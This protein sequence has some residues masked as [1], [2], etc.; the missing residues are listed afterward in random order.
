M[1]ASS[2]E[3]VKALR[4]SLKEVESLRRR[5]HALTTAAF[6]PIAIVGMACRYPGDV[7]S[8][9]E[10]WQL[11][12]SGG[13]AVSGFPEDRGWDVAGL[14][15]PDPDAVGK[16]Y[17]RSGGFLSGAA[18]FDP[19]FFGISPREATA[20]HPQQRVL[21]EV[22]WE[23]LE[24]AGVDPTAV[25]GSRTGVFAG[26][27]HQ[28]YA[29]RLHKTPDDL[30]GYLMTGSL[31]SVVS[32]RVAYTLGLE[33]PA[34]TV[35]TACSSSLVAL[36]LAGQSLRAGECSMALV[37][38]VTVMTTP[39]GFVEFSRQRGLSPDGRCK[40]FAASA[41][42]TGWG[43]GVGVLVLERLSDARRNNHRVLAVLRGSAIN[44]DGSSSGFSAPNGPAQERAITQALAD[45]RLGPH[46]V[47]AVEAHGTGTRLGDPIE[48][49]ALLATY[50]KGRPADQPLWLGSLKSNVG[51]TQAAAGVGGVIKMVQAMRH[52]VLPRTLHVDEPTP[53]VDWEA[54]TVRLLTEQR[55]WPEA[56]RPRR[57][58]VSSFGISGTNAHVI[59]E[60]APEQEVAPGDR[61]PAVDTGVVPVVV[62]ARDP[63]AL[64]AQAARLAAYV[65]DHPDADPYAIART[66]LTA[67]ATLEHRA[68]L[69]AHD[70]GHL[71]EALHAL[72]KGEEHPSVITGDA[73]HARPVFVFPG[74]G[75]QW[76]GMA[77]DLLNTSEV[78]RRSVAECED[79]LAPYVDWSLTDVLTN[80]QPIERVDIVQPALFAVMVSLARVWESLG[81]QPAAV[82]GHSQGEIPAAVIA[83]A[84]TLED[85]ARVTALRSQAIHATLTGHGAMASLTLTPE[86]TQQLPGAWGRELHIAAHNGPHT[87][88]VAGDAVAVDNL[89]AHCEERDI[90]ARRVNVDYASHTP[91]VEAISARLTDVLA[92]VKP[93]KGRI[94]FY[95][96]T[97]GEALDTT[98]LTADYWYTNLRQ[99]V[100]LT[101]ATT[102]ALANGHTT[103]VEISPHPI[104][105]T[106]L[107]DIADEVGQP[108]T[109]TATLRRDHGTWTQLLTHAAR[110]HAHNTPVNWAALLP[111]GG[112][113]LDLPTYP[114]QRQH[115]WIYDEAAGGG[116]GDQASGDEADAR[117]WAAVA[118][119]DVGALA[120]TLQIEDEDGRSSLSALLPTLSAWHRQHRDRDAVD[121]WRY[122][123]AWKPVARVTPAPLAG[124][125]LVALAAGQGMDP[126][127]TEALRVLGGHGAR[128]VPVE[129]T[130]ADADRD[131]LA[132]RLREVLAEARTTEGETEAAGVLSFVGLD[133]RP[134]PRFGALATGVALT[135]TL[136][137]A[138]SQLGARAPL[139]SVTRGAV[140]TGDSDAP[141]DPA[142]AQVWG[143]GRVVAL[144]H[145]ALWG[146]LVDLPESLDARSGALL[147]QVLSGATGE[148]QVA[149]RSAG[150]LARRM[151]SAA[152]GGRAARRWRPRGTVL[153]TGGTGSLAPRL[154]DW[155]AT[156]GAEHL[157]LVSRSGPAA[158]GAS[159]W[160]SDLERRGVGVTVAA[161][162]VADRD[163]VVALLDTL[164]AEGHTVRT[165]LHAAAFIELAPVGETSLTSMDAVLAA[166]VAGAA[167]LAELLD[168]GELDAFVLFSS[169]AGFWG[170]GDHAAY[171]AAN[172]ALDALAEQGRARGVPMTSVA[173]GVWEDAVHTWQNLDG[174][175]V[176]ETRARVRRQG[177][178]LMPAAL[179]VAALQQ[180]LDEDDTCVA[181]ADIDWERFV[182]LFTSMR[183]SRLLDALPAAR[184]L[185]ERSDTHDAEEASAGTDA[186]A[187]LRDRL[188][189]LT[190][191]DQEAALTE[192]ITRHAVVVLGL[193]T[194]E[195][196][197]ADRA[198]KD[199]GFDSLT[200]LALRNRLAEA[201][202]LRLPATLVFDYPTPLVL[203][204][205]LRELLVA[206]PHGP[207]ADQGAAPAATV[208]ATDNAAT[209]DDPIAIIAMACR[210]PGGVASPDDLW[211]L[212]RS[213]G[214]A[215]SA[216]PTDRGWDLA[217]SF[218][219]GGADDDDTGRR[220]TKEGGFLRDVAG[221]DAAFFGIGPREA[222][223]MDP[224]QRLVLETAWEAFERAGIDPATLRGSRTGTYIGAMSH[225][226]GTRSAD[227]PP[228]VQDYV[229]TGG[230]TSVISGRLAYTFG[231]EGPAVTVDTACSSSL[232][233][234]HLASQ[235]LRTGECTMALAGGVV[236]MPTPDVFTGFG[237]MGALS[238]SGRCMAFSDEADGFGL[239]EGAGMV[240]LERLSD[241][242]R[243]GHQ[244][245]AVIRGSATN[246]D[247]ASNGLA[248]PNGPSQQRVIRAA[249]ADARLA[250]NEVDAVEAHGTGTR[251]GDPIEAQALLATYGQNRP[252]DRPL[253]LGSVKSNIGHT[254]AAAGVAGVIKMV[255]AMRH[256]VLPRTLHV[257]KPTTHVD[258]SAGAVELLTEERAWVRGE[259][260]PR[261][262]AVSAFGISGTNAH[263]VLEEAPEPQAAP[264][265]ESTPD[266]TGVVP[267][268]LS[269]RDFHALRAQAAQLAA[270][271]EAHPEA[272]PYAIAHTLLT[273]RAT[274]EH[275]AVLLT[276]DRD[277]LR[278]ALQALANG[279][280]HPSVVT[281]N[282]NHTKPVFVFPG[283]GSQWTGMATDLLN[284]SEVF[285]QSI[286][287]CENALAPYV[288]WSLTDVL[289]NGQPIERVDIVQPALFAVMVSL[290]RVWESLG[291]QPTAVIGHSQGEIPAAVIAG[292]LTLED[293]ARVTALR[294]QAIHT[295]LTGHGTMA[296]LTLTPQATKQLPG[297][298]GREL[299][300]AAHN[301]PHTT[302]V[303]GDA[304]AVD[305]LLAH[306]DEHG[307]HARR[308]NV[309]YASHSPHVESVREQLLSQL[310]DLKPTASDIPFYSTTTGQAL[311]TT[312]LTAD[313]W[314][315]NLR[316][317]VLLTHAT[318]TALTNGHT[319][320]IEISPHPILTAPL[321]DIADHTNQ[322]ATIAATLRRDHGTWTQLLTHAA[323]LHTHNTPIN[324]TTHIPNPTHHHLDLP[325]YPFQRQHYWLTTPSTTHPNAH[326]AD[327]SFLLTRTTLATSQETL[328]T[329]HISTHTHPWLTDHAL[330][331]TPL[332]PGTAL[333]ELALHTAHH[334][335]LH[336][337]E[338][339][340]LHTP[341]TL[342][343]HQPH[344]LQIH[345]GTPNTTGQ[346][347]LTI[348]T[349]PQG[350][351]DGAWVQHASGSL[352]ANA[353]ADAGAEAEAASSWEEAAS[354]PPE[355]AVP[356]EVEGIYP[357]LAEGGLVYGPAFQGLRAAWR[358]GAEVFA[359]VRLPEPQHA[360]ADRFDLHPAL[361]DAALHATMLDGVER[362]VLPFS[363]RGVTLHATGA[364]DLRV[365]LTPTGPDT[366]SLA[367]ADG[368]GAPVA[369]V[370]A[371]AVR[372]VDQR[373]L[374][375]SGRPVADSLFQVAWHAVSADAP[376]AG[377]VARCAVVG[378]DGLGVG[379]AL[380][381]AGCAVEAYASLA[382]LARAVDEGNAGV[383]PVV[384]V[385]WPLSR[386]ADRHSADAASDAVV[387]MLGL[388]QEWVRDERFGDARL[389]LVTRGAVAV[390][391]AAEGGPAESVSDLAAA[392]V[393]GMVRSAQA[394]H[395][396]RF[397]LVD[398][399]ADAG[400]QRVLADVLAGAE[401]QCAVRAGRVWVPRLERSRPPATA[402]APASRSEGTVVITGG[403]GVLGS[404]VARH[405][406]THHGIRHLLLLSR[407]GPHAPN[408]TQLHHQLTQLGA[409]PTITTCDTSNPEQLATALAT[410]PPQHPLTGIIH[411]AGTLHDALL[412]N[413]T[414]QHTH[415]TLQPKTHT[416][417]HLH[418][419]TQHTPL[420]FF[421]LFS[422]AGGVL[423]SAGQANYAAANGYLDALADF[424]RG[425]GL[426]AVSMAWGL[427][428]EVS[429]MTGGLGEEGLARLRRAGVLPLSS[430]DGLAL[431]DLALG[432][433]RPLVLPVRLDLAALRARPGARPALLR[434]LLGAAPSRTVASSA[435]TA[436]AGTGDSAE[437]GATLALSGLPADERTHV[438]REL[439]RTQA[440]L[441]LGYAT[442]DA[443]EDERG[444]LDAGYD[445][446]RAVELRNRLSA[447]T[448]L[449]LPSTLVFDHPTPA[450][451]AGRLDELL[452]ERERPD[453][454]ALLA[455]LD[456]VAADLSAVAADDPARGQV[457]TRLRALLAGVVGPADG[458]GGAGGERLAVEGDEFADVSL[459]ELLDI[460]DDELRG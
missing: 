75:S 399:D 227:A 268:V 374:A 306:C 211:R 295:T 262:A 110:L 81:V 251:L 459:D 247:G 256:G 152:G 14:Y 404:L 376:G 2:E 127:V 137:Q 451:V 297:A 95:S 44:Q 230:V 94:P 207:A 139:W 162:D 64:R 257:S 174:V 197:R 317:P 291:V 239:S 219:I 342:T 65:E 280:E 225:G 315:T 335:G 202:G 392:S 367:V 416:A 271:V 385:P 458:E 314:Y 411:T 4:A 72:A 406:V 96:T 151:V 101:H 5:N 434:G 410:I 71:L 146:G 224:Q 91:H 454:R 191:T 57:A 387:R 201:T 92:E 343:H 391:P 187:E 12:A 373:Q 286:A 422:A 265:D 16:S 292:A 270:Y 323:H 308:I 153:I 340:T 62:S 115:L 419:L 346:H 163:A 250:P 85:G 150:L 228:A 279:D 6:E 345:I 185:L 386:D 350:T 414:P 311:D 83:G 165:V 3:V 192:L 58:A 332:L 348:H 246:Q 31:G 327:H 460:V 60:Q 284:T 184:R 370:A 372:P 303:A 168:P 449:R 290:A 240:V 320:F 441:V 296:S 289:T 349:R 161:C 93:R 119:G 375:V 288:D 369:T 142:Q 307:I 63:R 130:E 214:D 19:E 116:A 77:T 456:G 20:M 415:T 413:L 167:H 442:A 67:R 86:A 177:L 253:W 121:G 159:E 316:Q 189:T 128:I 131:A 208:A 302:V 438:L 457:V 450:E 196:A 245:L 78:F 172:A 212:V 360:D 26:V 437:P 394:E 135:L 266:E 337:I 48:A 238:A 324:W 30:E 178:P 38:G 448:G 364:T 405:L 269:A 188:T 352:S 344:Q 42:G 401:P 402:G 68:V 166:K 354:W 310:T 104:L 108:A 361:L 237:R 194:A 103:F 417:W 24:R 433:D 46:E 100:L 233:S 446:L 98:Q 436:P 322:P 112:P 281:G 141:A 440:A 88:V 368:R 7:S 421:I 319:T 431:F 329:G 259:A 453:A 113:Q 236:V 221:F 363:F 298:W 118:D 299:H 427:W 423:G 326:T 97:T 278:E 445:S 273:G 407:R 347:P 359:E 82:I 384:V 248:A 425:A 59:L 89:L 356:V 50:G 232:V 29:A 120:E 430:A 129:L 41:D 274:L 412:T 144:E 300:V 378:V 272:D 55:E 293:G 365:R 418:Q 213:G 382:D 52:G 181:V 102:T 334:T 157:V 79:A 313:Y 355:G 133:P 160:V 426:P 124:T 249:L 267:I 200:S 353:E 134:H 117:F 18:E 36:H 397:A 241:A 47:D 173:W 109:I 54:G 393:W 242:R 37:G 301:G 143:L 73:D 49:Q 420:D 220:R 358:R 287:E 380:L 321:H 408:A 198:F 190:A 39:I 105:T 195:S 444:F 70:R 357:R 205:H 45:A 156:Q 126:W 403:T 147:R 218:G 210:F 231:L 140:S 243:N 183:P 51:H 312:Q 132:A 11:V 136:V 390:A 331:N 84:L 154:T 182:P 400:S 145:P 28:D 138:L 164:R 223:A 229:I 222:L 409:T 435:S 318:T 264:I 285:R 283:Q 27:M 80:G 235:A 260:G 9:E 122:R 199:A 148:D 254:Q 305:N 17:T 25:R 383:P 69:L 258:W 351:D 362:V 330:W 377:R 439:V 114:F 215:I 261:R 175:D 176:Q 341:L 149:V 398:L 107:H 304:I 186:A 424:R 43:E 34:V 234:L 455:R 8:P 443:I 66:L 294:S 203:A 204:S 56:G 74:Q 371:L 53:H 388:F 338:E 209:D 263:V 169:I 23:A 33:G 328:Y 277:H 432:Q 244:V 61:G 158:P 125:W 180:A 275:R 1:T 276:H 76:A 32:G 252:D 123:I 429:E 40:A 447:A 155:L 13:D 325:T 193:S 428:E 217:E 255:Q 35:D 395:P 22:A 452:R 106:A 336:H 90:H 381:A 333:L 10:L 171:A 389:V 21:L 15:D 282:S 111:A 226:Y 216:P 396:D 366:M 87:T 179:A 309:D 170:S 206:A 379:P 99:P 339:L